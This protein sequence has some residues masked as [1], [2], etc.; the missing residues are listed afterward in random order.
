LIAQKALAKR[1]LEQESTHEV[2]REEITEWLIIQDEEA[3]EVEKPGKLE[4]DETEDEESGLG[5]TEEY[6]WTS[7]S[8]LER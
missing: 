2:L 7:T 5:A 4:E 8:T 6:D 1:F 3:D